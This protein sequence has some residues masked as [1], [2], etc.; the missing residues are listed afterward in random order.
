MDAQIADTCCTTF[1]KV[2]GQKAEVIY[3]PIDVW[4][5]NWTDDPIANERLKGDGSTTFRQNFTAWWA[6]YRDDIIKRDM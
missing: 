4:M 3:Q 1:E 6:L 2:T 5:K